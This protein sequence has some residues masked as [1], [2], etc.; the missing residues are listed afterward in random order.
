MWRYVPRNVRA[1][2]LKS[3]KFV[4]KGLGVYIHISDERLIQAAMGGKIDGLT[5]TSILKTNQKGFRIWKV[6]VYM[7]SI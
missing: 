5:V 3:I 1:R 4:L 6:N 2:R 7:D